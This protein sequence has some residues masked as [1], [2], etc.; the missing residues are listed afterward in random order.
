[1][2]ESNK[3]RVERWAGMQAA[4]APV[5]QGEGVFAYVEGALS[6]DYTAGR[7]NG[8]TT[9]ANLGSDIRSMAQLG[10]FVALQIDDEMQVHD[11]NDFI[12]PPGFE[13]VTVDG[14]PVTDSLG[15][16]VYART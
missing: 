9:Y 4:L 12:A 14:I 15:R 13:V 7:I 2:L 5:L 3:P 11:I 6:F 10:K 8:K 16:F 1:M